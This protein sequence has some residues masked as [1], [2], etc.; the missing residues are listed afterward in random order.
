MKKSVIL[1]H[2]ELEG[3]RDAELPLA[4][5][6][7]SGTL[8]IEGF[9][10]KIIDMSVMNDWQEK[11]MCHLKDSLFVGISAMTGCEIK[12]G[13]AVCDFVREMAP[14]LPI[15]WGGWHAST[16]P[17]QTLS[18]DRV[19]IVV[20]G[21]GDFV[22]VE[23]ARALQFERGLSDVRG[24][25]YKFDGQI[26]RNVDSEHINDL[27]V[28]PNT[29]WHLIEMSEYLKRQK[30]KRL[31]VVSGRGCAMRCTFCSH[32]VMPNSKPRQFSAFHVIDDIEK[33]IVKHNIRYVNFYE[34]TFISNKMRAM[35]ICNEIDRRKLKFEWR[36]SSRA[37]VISKLPNEICRKL[38][39]AGCQ[40]LSFGFESGSENVLRRIN[41]RSNCWEALESV[42]K[43]ESYGILVEAY[44]IFALPFETLRDIVDTIK[45]AIEIRK[46]A[47]LS[48]I[49]A[50]KYN[51]LPGTTVYKE[52][53]EK[54]GLKKVE[55]LEEWG[56]PSSYAGR[57]W[58][59]RLQKI[60]LK[61]AITQ[62]WLD[63]DLKAYWKTHTGKRFLRR[64]LKFFKYSIF[65]ALIW[66][67]IFVRRLF[68]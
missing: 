32:K 39:E 12:Y 49:W 14:S 28:L 64:I 6:A 59:S 34:P 66:W 50:G 67:I 41:K 63:P 33:V 44:L 13:L 11:I 60:F 4:C 52:C 36:G 65:K 43:C 47:P 48:D 40:K 3:V 37:N 53:I 18:D 24:I 15:V 55:S 61:V 17:D 38:R 7:L 54:Y 58:V 19:D 20:R 22:I 57:P 29:P 23:L 1:V 51:P 16:L 21:E 8:E 10:P 62:I 45:F 31:A 42:R 30:E 25:S 56:N 35:D 46:I 26:V 5:L 2:P 9:L 68:T 27:N